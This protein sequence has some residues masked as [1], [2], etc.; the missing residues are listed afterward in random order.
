MLSKIFELEFAFCF[1]PNLVTRRNQEPSGRSFYVRSL[2]FVVLFC[3]VLFAFDSFP[4]LVSCDLPVWLHSL[5]FVSFR[6]V[7]VLFSMHPPAMMMRRRMIFNEDEQTA[8]ATRAIHRVT[9]SQDLI[10]P[11]ESLVHGCSL[12]HSGFMTTLSEP[13]SRFSSCVPRSLNLCAFS[14]STYLRRRLL[15]AVVD[16][17]DDMCSTDGGLAPSKRNRRVHEQHA[18]N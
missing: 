7:S 4:D 6:F 11:S 1:F 9:I 12:S 18:D 13:V 15:A 5:R 17:Q 10:S 14:C 2:F 3:F 8:N 16:R